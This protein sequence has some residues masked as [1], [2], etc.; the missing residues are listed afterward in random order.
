MQDAIVRRVDAPVGVLLELPS[1]AKAGYAHV[2]NTGEGHVTRLEKLYKPGQTVPAKVI[3]TRPLDALVSLTL[4]A[5]EVE[6][7]FA[8]FE[9]IK[10]GSS[11]TGTVAAIENFG[12]FVTLSGSIRFE[13]STITPGPLR[14][15]SLI[16][17]IMI[18]C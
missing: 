1:I 16:V 18:G 7:S 13:P 12:M 17:V 9:Q 15:R 11:V 14:I 5:A 4:R 2:S 10:A 8:S 6:Q 3:G